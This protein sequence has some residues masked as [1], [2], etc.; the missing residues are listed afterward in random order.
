M[1]ADI[2]VD[3]NECANDTLHGCQHNCKNT[4]GSFEC[5]CSKGFRLNEVDGKSCTD[6][7]ECITGEADCANT[8]GC[9]NLVGG[10]ECLCNPG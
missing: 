3:V 6:V 5:L 7:D 2:C 9:R 4:E 10:Y 1:K 8:D